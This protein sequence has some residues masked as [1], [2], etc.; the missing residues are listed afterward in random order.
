MGPMGRLC[1]SV[2]GVQVCSLA[3]G[4]LHATGNGQKERKK[5]EERVVCRQ[6]PTEV[7]R[8]F[9]VLGSS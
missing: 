7:L 9:H 2:A 6:P 8:S 1:A 5:V 3:R 4:L